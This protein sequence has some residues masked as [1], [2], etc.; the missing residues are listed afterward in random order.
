MSAEG[1]IDVVRAEKAAAV[2]LEDRAKAK[3]FDRAV[4]LFTNRS[5]FKTVA[6][7]RDLFA[8]ERAGGGGS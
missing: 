7:L 1:K 4:E 2:L 3:A 8:Q 6:I 5:D